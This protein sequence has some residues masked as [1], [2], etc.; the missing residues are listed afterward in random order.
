MEHDPP[1]ASTPEM[2][3]LEVDYNVMGIFP[4]GDPLSR[5]LAVRH[6]KTIVI[7]FEGEYPGRSTLSTGTSRLSNRVPAWPNLRPAIAASV[8][9]RPIYAVRD[10]SVW[11]AFS[12]R[13]A[14]YVLKRQ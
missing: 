8:E 2:S 4:A 11:P 9:G 3:Q 10:T 7:E 12:G 14:R 6:N 13:L 5:T 1:P